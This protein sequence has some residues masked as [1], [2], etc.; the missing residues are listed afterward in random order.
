MF[1]LSPTVIP[2]CAKYPGSLSRAQLLV[3][4]DNK[5]LVGAFSNGQAWDRAVHCLLVGLFHP[6]SRELFW[7]RLHFVPTEDNSEADKQLSRL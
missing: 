2:F 5:A 4:V 6:Q 3:A 1:A 7:L